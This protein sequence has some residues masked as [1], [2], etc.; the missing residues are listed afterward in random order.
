MIAN[1]QAIIGEVGEEKIADTV[2]AEL[3]L[4]TQLGNEPSGSYKWISLAVR[5][6]DL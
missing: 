2:V 4:L 6:P 3:P 5:L 1:Q